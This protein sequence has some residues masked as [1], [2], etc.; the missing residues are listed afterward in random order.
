[1]IFFTSSST[2][3]QFVMLGMM[4]SD[5]ALWFGGIGVLGSL[6]GNKIVGQLIKKYKKNAIVVLLLAFVIGLSALI[7]GITGITTIIRDVINHNW[8]AFYFRG[9]CNT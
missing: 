5:Y 6:T 1:M 7:M 9:V 4:Q 8:V 2:T 3:V